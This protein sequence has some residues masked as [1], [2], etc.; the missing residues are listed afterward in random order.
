MMWIFYIYI[1]KKS[2]GLTESKKSKVLS[3]L[4]GITDISV[5]T[6]EPDNKTIR[7]SVIKEKDGNTLMDIYRIYE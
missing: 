4:E 3:L 6:L 5:F 7:Q 2:D 1:Q